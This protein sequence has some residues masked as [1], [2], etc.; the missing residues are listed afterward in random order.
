MAE[1]PEYPEKTTDL[2]QVT[3]KLYHIICCIKQTSSKFELT[4]LVVM[5]TDCIGNYKSNF[6]TITTASIFS[7]IYFFF[8]GY[9]LFSVGDVIYWF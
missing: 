1:K 5:G 8:K 2:P 4:T 6:Y 7:N 9:F 3:D